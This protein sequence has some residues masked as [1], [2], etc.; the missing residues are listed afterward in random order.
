MEHVKENC[1]SNFQ[2]WSRRTKV[3]KKPSSSFRSAK[4]APTQAK[5]TLEWG[6]RFLFSLRLV[7][8]E[9]WKELK[10]NAFHSAA[11]HSPVRGVFGDR[12]NPRHPQPSL[13]GLTTNSEK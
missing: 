7:R 9:H 6:T 2:L 11:V 3:R 1:S 13:S 5:V 12:G 8:R 10:N 4:V